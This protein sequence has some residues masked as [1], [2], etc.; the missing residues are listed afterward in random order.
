MALPFNVVETLV[1]FLKREKYIETVGSDGIGE[2]Q[3]Q[4]AQQMQGGRY[5]VDP[6]LEAYVQQVK[7]KEFPGPEHCFR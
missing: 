7:A 4:P 6:G 5:R 1:A 2:Q 3:Y